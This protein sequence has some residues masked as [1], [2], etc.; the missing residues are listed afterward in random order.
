M[1][2]RGA[3]AG[4]CRPEFAGRRVARRRFDSYFREYVLDSKQR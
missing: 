1:N 4:A 2:R 3:K